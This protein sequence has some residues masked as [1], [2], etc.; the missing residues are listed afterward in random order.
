MSRPFQ[1]GD[2]QDAQFASGDTALLAL[3]YSDAD[4]SLEGW[5][6]TGHLVSSEH[7]WI[8]VTLP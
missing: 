7:G 2:P 4:E 3:A 5:T 8:E 6:D 1:T